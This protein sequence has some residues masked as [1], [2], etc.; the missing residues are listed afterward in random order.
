MK[1]TNTAIKSENPSVKLTDGLRLSYKNKA[2]LIQK[3]NNFENL[4]SSS[5]RG[6]S[7]TKFLFIKTKSILNKTNKKSEEP[8]IRITEENHVS[9]N[10]LRNKSKDK[11]DNNGS[12]NTNHHIKIN[13]LSNIKKECKIIENNSSNSNLLEN[14]KFNISLANLVT[15][16]N[17]NHNQSPKDIINK[18]P[19]SNFSKFTN[20]TRH[21][22]ANSTSS[23]RGIL[24][25]LNMIKNKKNVHKSK[26]ESS[27]NNISFDNTKENAV[28]ST[29]KS[30][31]VVIV[32]NNI[33]NDNNNRDNINNLN[34]SF[35]N[36]NNNNVSNS[37]RKNTNKIS[38]ASSIKASNNNNLVRNIEIDS[39][40][41]LHF[42]YLNY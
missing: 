4:P 16:S 11:V 37:N 29:N 19:T 38:T 20:N 23:N 24:S 17:I 22:K 30:T 28:I 31:N 39:P 9:K 6:L 26:N 41:E 12:N 2:E 42:F 32:D 40:E 33:L 34:N 36:N 8:N 27:F 7:E 18:I 5:N 13:V 3:A 10:E 25:S 35:N 15:N 21:I 14:S 1:K